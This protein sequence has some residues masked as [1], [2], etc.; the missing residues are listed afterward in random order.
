MFVI[1]RT[2]YLALSST[3]VV[4]SDVATYASLAEA[5]RAAQSEPNQGLVGCAVPC[6][7]HVAAAGN[8]LVCLCS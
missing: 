5:E 1:N 8:T 6:A 4:A 2:T 7:R 3:A